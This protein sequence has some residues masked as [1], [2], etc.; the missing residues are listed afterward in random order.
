MKNMELDKVRKAFDHATP[1]VLDS[2]LSDCREQKGTIVM[3]QV[4]PHW[5]K[6][7]VAAAA[8]VVLVL[9]L[10][11][12]MGW[13][14]NANMPMA[15]ISLDVNPSIQL[16]VNRN[17]K[18][19]DAEALNMDAQTVLEDMDLEGSHINV[20]VNAILG[21]M[22][23]N[24]FLSTDANTILISVNSKDAATGAKLEEKL[25]EEIGQMLSASNFTA[26]LMSQSL[27][28]V[29]ETQALAQQYNIS[30]GKV[31]LIQK[32]LAADSRYTFENLAKL[33]VNELKLLTEK[34]GVHLEDVT[35]IGQASNTQF[36]GK[37]AALKIALDCADTTKERITDLEVE[38]DCDDGRMIYE[39]AFDLDPYDYEVDIDARTGEV[40]KV[41]KDLN[42]DDDDDKQPVVAPQ[43]NISPEQAKAAAYA[44]AG[45]TAAQ[46]WDVS[47]ELEEDDG[48]TYYEIEFDT[49]E[50]EYEYEVDPIT[51]QA[52]LIERDSQNDD[53]DD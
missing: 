27:T 31:Q 37:E 24:H 18:V 43:N 4:K 49:T 17:E 21:S 8:A 32:I 38:F 16:T 9:G 28:D 23:R 36:I 42:D 12:G 14:L 35:A 30:E 44:H 19:L 51:G 34:E 25:T 2:V 45:V 53:D 6:K 20:A 33:S 52:V 5:H 41:D 26:A 46:V 47:C 29:E 40:L 22:L 10:G 7:F 11:G 15:A 48:R 50:Y 39:V 3:T 13:H 1:N